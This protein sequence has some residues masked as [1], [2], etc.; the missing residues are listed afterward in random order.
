MFGSRTLVMTGALFALMA[1]SSTRYEWHDY[2]YMVYRHLRCFEG[3]DTFAEGLRK[4]VADE[5]AERRIPPGLFAAYGY[6]L[7]EMSKFTEAIFY[8]QKEYDK[9][10][11]S[12]ALMNTMIIT[13]ETR[14]LRAREKLEGAG[15][16]SGGNSK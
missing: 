6:E 2:D 12:R 14:D 8:F 7:Y 16:K 15:R 4:I 9:W 10:P 13:A 3:S 1:C 11:E 5:E